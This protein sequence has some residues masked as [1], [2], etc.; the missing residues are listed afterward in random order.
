MKPI[1]AVT[2]KIEKPYSTSPKAL[3]PQRL[4]EVT[5]IRKIVILAQDGIEGLQYSR[6]ITAAM[7]SVGMMT[8]H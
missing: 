4:I 3:M 8:R 7:I 6:V 5:T 2:F 1:M